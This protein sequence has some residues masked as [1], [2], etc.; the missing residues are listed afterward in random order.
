MALQHSL[1][2]VKM[3]MHAF[4]SKLEGNKLS[5]K[6]QACTWGR[7]EHFPSVVIEQRKNKGMSGLNIK[8]TTPSSLAY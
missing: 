1:Q 6:S 3:L 8:T 2:F 4:P 5:E 7:S